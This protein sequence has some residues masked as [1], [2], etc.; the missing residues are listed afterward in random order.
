M[1]PLASAK[2]AAKKNVVFG[3]LAEGNGRICSGMAPAANGEPESIV[4][5]PLGVPDIRYVP[6]LE[7]RSRIV[8]TE[9]DPWRGRLL[10]G[11]VHDENCWAMGGIAGQEDRADLVA[12]G[13][14]ADRGPF[15]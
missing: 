1:L 7:A 2:S 5:E 3:T 8:C 4:S 9:D 13:Q 14:K 15:S 11:E 12:V 10:R 6:T